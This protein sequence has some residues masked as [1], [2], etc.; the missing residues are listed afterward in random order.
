MAMADPIAGL[1]GLALS[2]VGTVS[3]AWIDVSQ[4]VHHP[5]PSKVNAI[6]ASIGLDAAPAVRQ[7]RDGSGP[8][9]VARVQTPNGIRLL[10]AA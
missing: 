7:S 5:E 6:F 2:V 4:I 3:Q 1:G 10:S 8:L 9:L